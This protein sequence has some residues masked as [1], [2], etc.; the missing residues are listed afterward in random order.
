MAASSLKDSKSFTMSAPGV[1]QFVLPSLAIYGANASG[2]TNVLKSLR[3]MALAVADSHRSWKPGEP[4]GRQPF[5]ENGSPSL[6]EIDFLLLGVRYCYGFRLN[7]AA[8]LE[9]WLYAY[10]RGKKQTWFHRHAGRPMI[11]SAKL[12]GP[13]KAIEILMRKDSLFLSTAAQNNH[14]LLMPIY[15]WVSNLRLAVIGLGGRALNDPSNF[16][17]TPLL[18][19][20]H[21]F[22]ASVSQLVRQADLGIA[23]IAVEEVDFPESVRR[24]FTAVTSELPKN[25]R[26]RLVH[27]L[28]KDSAKFDEDMES[29]GTLAYLWVLGP[30]LHALNRG[31]VLCID[32]LESSLHPLLASQ[33]VR[34]FNE[35][36]TNSKGAQLIFNTHDATL[37]DL[38]NLR[39]DQ[40]W[41]TEKSEEGTSHLYPLTDFKPRL[42][43]NL[44][45]GYLQGRY[46]AIP[47]LGSPK[48][49]TKLTRSHAKP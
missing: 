27:Q 12:T 19:D 22:K 44:R 1:D 28:G 42:N 16:N 6:H 14:E 4:I 46:G 5:S 45:S 29:T 41:F 47:F 38:A 15:L 26:L 25:R 37:L 18:C 34:L 30:I 11:F 31:A 32:E 33:L 49:L 35:K 36:S 21:A 3:F 17:V 23:D 10:P 8:I 24:S 39:R 13:N 9:E 2:K 7:D 40:I 48:L 20:D 43:E